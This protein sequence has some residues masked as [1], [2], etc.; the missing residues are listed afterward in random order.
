MGI[1]SQIN[2]WQEKIQTRYSPKLLSWLAIAF[3]VTLR[4]VQYFH[5]RSL[6]ADEAVLALNIIDRNYL[7]LL[8]PLDYNQGAPIGFL[9]V[10]KLAIQVL[11][12]SEYAFRLFPFL[13]G[14]ISIFLFYDLAKRGLK[15]YGIPIALAFFGVLEYLVYYTSELKQYSSDVAIALGLAWLTQDFIRRELTPKYIAI[16]GMIGAVAI[17]FSHPAVLVAG[18][19]A[20]FSLVKVWKTREFKKLPQLFAI[21][22]TWGVSFISFYLVSIQSLAANETLRE[23]WRKAFPSELTDI[24]WLVDKWQDLFQNPLG[25]EKSLV[26]LGIAVFFIGIFSLFRRHRQTLAFVSS[27]ILA[28]L[29]ATYLHQYPFRNRLLLFLIP[30]IIL[31]FAEGI[32]YIGK[33]TYLKFSALPTILIFGLFAIAPL[34]HSIE[35]L[36][37]PIEREEIRP[38]LTYIKEH[39]KPGDLL[40]IFQRGEYQF[41]YYAPKFG[42][43]EG[44][45]IVGV[46]DLEDGKEVSSEEW[47][48]YT[49]DFDAL[50]GNP[51]V[52]LLFS[53]VD[54]FDEERERVLG[55]IDSLG[56]KL[57]RFDRTGAFV[58][59]YDFSNEAQ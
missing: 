35:L 55:Y 4:I 44:D 38:V 3:A 39:K 36:S 56:T 17:W 12:D 47:E 6:W 15:H 37:N 10:E 41:Q 58:C 33:K 46:D 16:Y 8:Q 1:T 19:F 31:L 45:Y 40:Y 14:I 23:S 54:K 30:F 53:H 28:T 26:N 22:A 5:N 52:W 2:A 7:Q 20:I 43:A 11:G 13:C 57:D 27:P 21:F 9:W 24:N 29:L 48:R 49:A 32:Y 34:S 50:Q 18:G 25:F 59:L 42:Y 51:R